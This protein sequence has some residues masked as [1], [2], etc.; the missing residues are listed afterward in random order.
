[1]EKIFATCCIF[2]FHIAI[3]IQTEEYGVRKAV[4]RYIL[5]MRPQLQ[6]LQVQSFR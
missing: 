5:D 2:L 1:M 4:T 3:V 6:K